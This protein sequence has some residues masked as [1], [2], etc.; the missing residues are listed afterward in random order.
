MK[1]VGDFALRTFNQSLGLD[2]NHSLAKAYSRI[3]GEEW[4]QFIG[5]TVC[6]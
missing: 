5:L 4:K 3:L 6:Y 2:L 1:V